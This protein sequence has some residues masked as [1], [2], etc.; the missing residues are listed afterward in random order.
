MTSQISYPHHDRVGD[1]LEVFS[2]P[3]RYVWPSELDVRRKP[4]GPAV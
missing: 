2:A 4:G 3:Y 1:T